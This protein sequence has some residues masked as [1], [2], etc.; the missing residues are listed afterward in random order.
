MMQK[1]GPKIICVDSTHKTNQY[2]FPL[3]NFIVPDEF[4]KG[5]P[6]A[7]LISNKADEL[8][9]RPFLEEIKK[10]CAPDFKPN[11]IMTD[12]DNTSYNAFKNV[13]GSEI[14]FLCKWHIKRAWKNKLP[15]VGSREATVT[16]RYV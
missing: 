1:H 9:Q 10:R 8:T 11:V 7:H 12:D 5:Y 2:D 13:F 4:N 14:H 16:G 3:I 15:L 6:V